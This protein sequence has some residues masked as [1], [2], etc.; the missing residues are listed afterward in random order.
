LASEPAV[1]AAVVAQ[2]KHELATDSEWVETVNTPQVQATEPDALFRQ[3]RVPLLLVSLS[4][5]DA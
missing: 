4:Y 5:D 2:A 3:A 1:A